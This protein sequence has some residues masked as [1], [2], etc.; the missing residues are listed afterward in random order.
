MGVGRVGDFN[1]STHLQALPRQIESA[2]LLVGFGLAVHDRIVGGVQLKNS[3][4][5]MALEVRGCESVGLWDTCS[6]PDGTWCYGS[7][8]TSIYSL[9]RDSTPSF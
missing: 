7:V 2:E 1:V 9:P 8:G 6:G 3:V 4:T 5:C